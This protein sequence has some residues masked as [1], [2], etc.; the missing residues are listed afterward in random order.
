MAASRLQRFHKIV[1]WKAF[2]ISDTKLDS[3]PSRSAQPLWIYCVTWG[4]AS[5]PLPVARCL[6]RRLGVQILDRRMPVID[7]F[8]EKLREDHGRPWKTTFDHLSWL[9][10]NFSGFSVNLS[11]ICRG[12]HNLV[13]WGLVSFPGH[14][15]EWSIGSN[16]GWGTDSVQIRPD[17]SSRPLNWPENA[18]LRKNSFHHGRCCFASSSK[19]KLTSNWHT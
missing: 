9:W 2:R 17:P 13:T 11:W 16:G 19:F 3:W 18:T 6:S 12:R 10:I 8:E 15:E 5:R 4:C 14:L 7:G 1:T